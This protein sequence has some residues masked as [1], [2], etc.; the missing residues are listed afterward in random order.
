M[1]GQQT[2]CIASVVFLLICVQNGKNIRFI[3][4]K[5]FLKPMLIKLT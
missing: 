1:I 5:N 2:L 4:I 3:F